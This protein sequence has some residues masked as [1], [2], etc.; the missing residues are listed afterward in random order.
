MKQYMVVLGYEVTYTLKEVLSLIRCP[1][2][3]RS[4]QSKNGC[5]LLLFCYDGK[6]KIVTKVQCVFCKN[7][8]NRKLQRFH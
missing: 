2:C 4:L 8:F 6:D 7:I 1:L 3:Q 5:L